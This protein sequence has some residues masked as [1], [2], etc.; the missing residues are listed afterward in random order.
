MPAHYCIDPLDP[1]AEREVF[2]QYEVA[3][4]CVLI[5][6]ALDEDGFDILQ[7]LSDEC[8]RILQL[9]ITVYHGHLKPFAWA[10]QAVDVLAAPEAA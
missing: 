5:K 4:P 10:Q 2:V 6:S 3:R 7:D 1:Y 9:E 8:V